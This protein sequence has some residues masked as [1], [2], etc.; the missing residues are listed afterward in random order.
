MLINQSTTAIDC[1]HSGRIDKQSQVTKILLSIADGGEYTIG[2]I[3]HDLG[4]QNSTVSA[5]RA[6][7]LAR[8]FVVKGKTRRCHISGVMCETIILNI[9]L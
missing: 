7:L 9:G 2:E 5:R 6:E 3:A 8:E 4:M 1:F